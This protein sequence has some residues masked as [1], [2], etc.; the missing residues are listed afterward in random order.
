MNFNTVRLVYFSPTKTTQKILEGIAQGTAIGKVEHLDL[1]P[2]EAKTA[3]PDEMQDELVLLGV[4]VYGGRVPLEAVPRLQQLK[5]NATPAVIIVVYGNREFEDAL[6]EL[7][8]LARASG[9]IPVAGGAFIGEH[10]FASDTTPIANGRPDPEDL[11]K[12][13]EFGMMIRGKLK[14][15]DS[16]DA[17]SRLEVP[18]NSPYKKRRE[19]AEISAIDSRGPVYLV[20]NLRLTLSCCSDYGRRNRSD[21]Q[22][23]VHFMLCMCEKLSNRSQS[24]GR[25]Q[26]KTN[27]AVVEHKLSDAKGA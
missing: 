18:G 4:P 16:I 6:L 19:P 14:G 11:K 9:F 20:W 23:C 17:V 26:D 21:R 7:R 24:D 3:G 27:G 13:K 2:P 22:A 5:A 15:I 25:T 10:S 8:D 1:T 12:A